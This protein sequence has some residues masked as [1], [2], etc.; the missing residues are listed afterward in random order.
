VGAGDEGEDFSG[1]GAVHDDDG[2]AGGGVDT[3]K[4]F[5]IAGG[6]LAGG[7]GGSADGEARLGARRVKE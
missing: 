2:D 4:N 1:L 3:S 5:E 7:S 6:F